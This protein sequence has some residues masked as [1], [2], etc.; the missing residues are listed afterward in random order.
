MTHT[1][2]PT[3]TPK[4]PSVSSDG[5]GVDTH[6]L[7]VLAPHEVVDA[8]VTV[9][10]LGNLATA[11][12]DNE[13]PPA[14]YEHLVARQHGTEQ[15]PVLPLSLFVDGV[16]YSHTDSVTGFWLV[17]VITCAR[18][19]WCVLCKKL[20]CVCGCRGWCTCTASSRPA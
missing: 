19:L 8:G 5:L 2:R 18:F 13:L 11:V 15:D 4:V 16:P 20:V 10:V 6:A 9:A 1:W 14:Y 7:H 17:D 12:A 3:P